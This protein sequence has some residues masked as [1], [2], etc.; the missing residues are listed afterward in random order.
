M[1][2]AETLFSAKQVAV[3]LGI[4]GG[5]LRRYAIAYESITGETVK[6]HPRDGRQ[7]T[8]EQVETLQR[9][10]SYVKANPG[11]GVEQALR[12]ALGAS[13]ADAVR[14]PVPLGQVGTG[15][16]TEALAA[17]LER[18][19]S[20]LLD[21]LQALRQSNERLIDELGSLKLNKPAREIENPAEVAPGD[22]TADRQHG[23]LIR[24]LIRLESFLRG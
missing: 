7:Y 12:L 14:S 23:L 24:L 9:A 5:M 4:S 3:T 22:A 15:V 8:A 2:E 11:M 16:G 19:V 21:E 1:S 13:Q 17:T 10:K 6:Q 20:P 18:V